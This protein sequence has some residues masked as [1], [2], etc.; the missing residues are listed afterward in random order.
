ALDVP[1]DRVPP[2]ALAFVDPVA[3]APRLSDAFAGSTSACDQLSPGAIQVSWG[4]V[5][6]GICRALPDHGE[7]VS[8]EERLYVRVD[9]RERPPLFVHV[10]LDSAGRSASLTRRRATTGQVVEPGQSVTLGALDGVGPVGLTLRSV[11]SAVAG[12]CTLT[13][14]A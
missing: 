13:V 8:P 11:A 12:P 6:G 14:I 2:G 1:G 10:L 5:I 3:A 7:A 4:L 9:N